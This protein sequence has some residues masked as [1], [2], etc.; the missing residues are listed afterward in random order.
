M[1]VSPVNLKTSPKF[2]TRHILP[3][4]FSEKTRDFFEASAAVGL[5]SIPMFILIYLHK[6]YEDTF[7]K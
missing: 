4:S 6:L 7:K 1:R 3:K 5:T 2:G